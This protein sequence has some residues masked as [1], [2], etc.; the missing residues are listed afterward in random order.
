MQPYTSRAESRHS[1][2]VQTQLDNMM[3][4][5]TRGRDQFFRCADA[6]NDRN[7]PKMPTHTCNL[8]VSFWLG[9]SASLKDFH[10]ITGSNFSSA[11]LD[12]LYER[13]LFPL[14]LG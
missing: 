7:E 5:D 1:L 9:S 14:R 2:R 12:Y 8:N 3:K 4:A 6:A 10:A 13:L 11:A